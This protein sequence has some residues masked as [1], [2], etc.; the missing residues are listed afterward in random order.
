MIRQLR[1]IKDPEVIRAIK[2]ACAARCKNVTLWHLGMIALSA[3]ST[4]ALAGAIV[5]LFGL[6]GAA[7]WVVTFFCVALSVTVFVN[8][9]IRRSYRVALPEILRSLGRCAECGYDLTGLQ[10]DTCPECGTHIGPNA[11]G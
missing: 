2:R 10:S 11:V 5:L 7:A 1:S 4:G 6:R 8:A 9:M 3:V